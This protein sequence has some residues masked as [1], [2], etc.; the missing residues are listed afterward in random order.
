MSVVAPETSPLS[1]FGNF[2]RTNPTIPL[3]VLLLAI[4]DYVCMRSS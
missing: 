1:R 3:A 2:L 4:A